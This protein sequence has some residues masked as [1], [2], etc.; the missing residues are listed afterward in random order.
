VSIERTFEDAKKEIVKHPT[1][2]GVTAVEIMEI[3]PDF[4]VSIPSFTFY[5]ASS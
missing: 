1:K 2:P 3:L 4:D 5:K